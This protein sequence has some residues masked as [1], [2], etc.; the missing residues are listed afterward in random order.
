LARRC[1]C[2][3]RS[4]ARCRCERATR[5]LGQEDSLD[6]ERILRVLPDLERETLLAQYRRAVDGAR[7]PAGWKHLQPFPRLRAGR[8]IS[9]NRPGFYEARARALAGTGEEWCSTTRYALLPGR[10]NYRPWLEGDALRQMGGLPHDAC[11]VTGD[12]C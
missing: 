2:R 4:L 1:G 5:Q 10:V 8:V 11:D 3:A 12:R 6:P 7:D 9:A